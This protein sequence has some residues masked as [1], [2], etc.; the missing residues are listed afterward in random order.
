GTCGYTVETV[1]YCDPNT[2]KLSNSDFL[3]QP[4]GGNSLLE[5]SVEYRIPLNFGPNIRHFFAAMFIDGGVVG[6][7]NIAG[8]SSISNIVKG[9]GAITPGVGLRYQ[10][11]VGPI[12]VDVA[13]NPNRAEDL[14]VV[15]AVRDK[16]GKMVMVPLLTSRNFVQ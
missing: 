14:G 6:K 4:L 7:G 12:R 2:S 5:G 11:P 1:V 10:S 8:L 15:T 9:T 3:P 13:I 16:T